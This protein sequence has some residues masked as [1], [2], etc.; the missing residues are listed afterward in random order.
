[1]V[2]TTAPAIDVASKTAEATG[3][4]GAKVSYTASARDLVDGSTTVSCDVA[5]GSLFELGSTTVT[6]ESRDSRNNFDKKSSPSRWST[7]PRLRSPPPTRPRRPPAPTAR[8]SSS[9]QRH[10]P[11]RRQPAGQ[12]HPRL[13]QHLHPRRHAGQLHRRP[14]SWQQGHATANVTVRDT[15]GPV[16]TLADQTIEAAGPDGANASFTPTAKD[17]VSGD[18]TVTC[19]KASGEHL[20]DRSDHGEVLGD[21]RG[22]QRD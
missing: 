19:D 20:P 21:R 12:L 10:G 18:R 11:G 9:G 7:P 5:S 6:C 17:L 13:G 8:R 3:P 14:T 1:V 15:T 4:D 2:D 16:L 22:R